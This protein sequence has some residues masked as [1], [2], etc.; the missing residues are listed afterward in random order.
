MP[1]RSL[2]ARS[3]YTI[4]SPWRTDKLIVS[5]VSLCRA[6]IGDC[7]ASRTDKRAFTRLPNSSNL[8]P[9]R[10]VPPSPLSTILQ[11]TKSFKMRCAVEACSW[12]FS[13]RSLRLLDS[14][15]SAKASTKFIMRS[16]TWIAVFPA[17]PLALI[18]LLG[19]GVLISPIV[20]NLLGIAY[21]E[22]EFQNRK[23]GVFS[24]LKPQHTLQSARDP[25]KSVHCISE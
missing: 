2:Y 23:K 14:S 8:R 19:F 5:P 9:N 6:R 22:I 20:S 17:S 13:A 21:Y 4:S 18:D 24:G 3:T 12:V 1:D 7:A 16:T 25:C 11:A 15:C 10:Y